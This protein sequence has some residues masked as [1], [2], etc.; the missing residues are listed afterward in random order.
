MLSGITINLNQYLLWIRNF[1]CVKKSP[2]FVRILVFWRNFWGFKKKKFQQIS[3]KFDFKVK[4]LILLSNYG[5][6]WSTFVRILIFC[7]FRSI[8]IS[9]KV[10]SKVLRSKFPQSLI[11]RSAFW[12]YKVRSLIFCFV[13]DQLFSVLG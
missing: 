8:F 11:S 10:N 9:V 3:E 4:I 7:F 5:F 6:I 12:F 1:F 2:F 13:L